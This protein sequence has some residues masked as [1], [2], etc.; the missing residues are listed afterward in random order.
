MQVGISEPVL[1]SED[2]S[3]SALQEQAIQEEPCMEDKLTDFRTACLKNGAA[4][5]SEG[6]NQD[7][8]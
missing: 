1:G 3:M 4:D 8:T 6:Q 2:L 7:F 5:K